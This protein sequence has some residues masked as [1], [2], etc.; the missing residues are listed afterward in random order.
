MIFGPSIIKGEPLQGTPRSEPPDRIVIHESAGPQTTRER[1]VSTLKNRGLSSHFTVEADG[2]VHRHLADD[3]HGHHAGGPWNELSFGYD[4]INPVNPNGATPR[5]GQ[6]VIDAAYAPQRGTWN[7]RVVLGS[8]AQLEAEWDLIQYL[9]FKHSI[10]LVFP[11]VTTAANGQRSYRWTFGTAVLPESGGGGGPGIWAHANFSRQRADGLT[12]LLY[13]VLR[14]D[15]HGP[16]EARQFVMD[17][18]ASAKGG[19]GGES[20]LPDAPLLGWF[21]Q[22]VAAL[23]LGT[24]AA[25]LSGAS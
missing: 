24:L 20:A 21:N 18:A 12:S 17:L 8:A 1:T 6:Q 11:A 10:P 19:L 23:F 4:S 22:Q 16:E 13:A 25:L 5:P 2:S 14:H 9:A 15:G 7:G 3:E